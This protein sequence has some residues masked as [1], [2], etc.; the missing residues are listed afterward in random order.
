MRDGPWRGEAMVGGGGG[1][2][3]KRTE[4]E[5]FRRRQHVEREGDFVLVAFALEPAE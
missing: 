3:A 4:D 2:E 1:G 5:L